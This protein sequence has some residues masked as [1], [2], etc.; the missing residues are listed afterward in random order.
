MAPAQCAVRMRGLMQASAIAAAK[1]L[2]PRTWLRHS[3]GTTTIVDAGFWKSLVPKPLRKE[4]RMARSKEWNPATYF[5]VMFLFVGSMSIQMIA[6]R[7]QTDQY[8]R[9]SAVRIGLL[10]EVVDKIRNGEEVD[11]EG[12]LGT[13]DAQREADWEEI[14]QGIE[15]D[16]AM[17]KPQR[18]GK[19]K[20]SELRETKS[21]TQ[22]A[23]SE[24]LLSKTKT[25]G[26]GSF[27]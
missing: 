4:N 26:L 2:H 3:S 1:P 25:G 21:R 24:P 22:A 23:A 27:F 16:D 12:I 5:I 20:P 15:R 19:S 6:L 10:R 8:A 13:G 17:R 9:Q 7:M 11:V 14:L 18:Q